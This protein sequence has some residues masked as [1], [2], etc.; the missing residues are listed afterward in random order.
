[1][2]P[3]IAGAFNSSHMKIRARRESAVDYFSRYQEQDVVVQTVV[4]EKKLFI[5]VAAAFPGSLHDAR[6]LRNSSIYLKAENGNILS[7]GPMH[8]IGTEEIQP[9][10]V[11]N[12]AYPLSP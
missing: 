5:D 2:L 7:A 1:M 6:V 10:L 8:L 4:N 3:N 11:G 9:Y 12:S